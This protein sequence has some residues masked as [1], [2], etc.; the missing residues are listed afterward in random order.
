MVGTAQDIN[1]V[2]NP[3]ALQYAIEFAKRGWFVFPLQPGLK[4][5]YA[6]F[7]WKERST[8]DVDIIRKAGASELYAGCNWALDTGRSEI[9]V[10]DVD[11]K[12]DANGFE[13]L[14]SLPPI[15]S[16]FKVRTPS[17]GLHIYFTGLGPNTVNKLGPGLDSRGVGGYVL[18]PGSQVNGRFYDIIS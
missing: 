2:K 12:P 7:P 3:S 4:V 9:F 5:P 11:N 18:I 10:L 17:G 16:P 14:K 6:G 8:N 1:T 15:D 13:S